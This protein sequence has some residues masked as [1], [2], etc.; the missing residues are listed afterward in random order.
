MKYKF[1]VQNYCYWI[2]DYIGNHIVWKIRE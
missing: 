1:M 2:L